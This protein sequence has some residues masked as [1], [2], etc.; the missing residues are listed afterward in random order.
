MIGWWGIAERAADVPETRAEEIHDDRDR[1]V[2]ALFSEHRRS[3]IRLA[4]LLGADDA[5]DIVSEAF[6]HLYRRWRR[7]R[8][9]DAALAYLR[10]VVI[11][12]TRMRLRHLQVARRQLQRDSGE[13]PA[14]SSEALALLRDDQRAVVAALASLPDRQ[15]EALVLR[16]WMELRER[17][18]ADAMGISPGAVKTHVSRGMAALTRAMEERR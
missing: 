15:R 5:E 4:V 3:L 18:I 11:N 17:E 12:R 2:E 16:Y 13:S 1:A 6:Y 8:S 10:S 9:T 14:V 7:L